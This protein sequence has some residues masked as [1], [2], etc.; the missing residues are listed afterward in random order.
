MSFY[1]RRFA[2]LFRRRRRHFI[3]DL[4]LE[5]D[6]VVLR[7]N[8]NHPGRSCATGAGKT[9][10]QNSIIQLSNETT[11]SRQPASWW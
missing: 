7:R 5:R 1:V 10:W 11:P 4:A 2:I 8:K 9:V 6:P 3:G